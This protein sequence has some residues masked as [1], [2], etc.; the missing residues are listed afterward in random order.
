M[1][2]GIVSDGQLHMSSTTIAGERHLRIVVTAPDTNE[3][4]IDQ[5]LDTLRVER[6]LRVA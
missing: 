3:D 4:T 6:S 5:L 2:A 1:H